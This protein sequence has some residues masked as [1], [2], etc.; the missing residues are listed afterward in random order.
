[1]FQPE[2]VIAALE[3]KA[4]HFAGYDGEVDAARERY[5]RALETLA[6]LSR[7][8]I[9]ARL[10]G[11][12]W[13]GARPTAE[14]DA[15]PGLVIPFEQVWLNHERARAWAKR[16]LT[17]VTTVAVDGSQI[18]P[19]RTISAPVG[20]VQ[21]GWFINPHSTRQPY[22][23]DIA[24]EV[25]A[26]DELAD[27]DEAVTGFPDWRVNQ[28]RFERECQR[29]ISLMQAFHERARPETPTPVFFFDG[30]LILSFAAQMR[31]ARQ[32]P[33][34]QA[35]RALLAASERYRVPVVGYVDVSYA[36][37]L[38]SMLG[39]LVGRSDKSAFS[40]GALLRSRMG[41]GDR[42][43]AWICARDDGLSQDGGPGGY[44]DQVAFVYLKTTADRPPARL[45]LPRWLLAEGEEGEDKNELE[46][47][48]DVVRAE[49]IVGNGYPYAIETADAVAV[50]TMQDRERFYRVFQAFIE[51]EG[52]PLR[53]SRKMVSKRGR[54]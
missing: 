20:A 33:Y 4:D 28:R 8:E 43:T 34:V 50:I 25:L 27:E 1:M 6:D 23:K 9:D 54:R 41:W 17:G 49:C 45:D 48:V 14:H 39:L 36:K 40:D 10:A 12:A 29:L 2:K 19:T 32:R 37:D 30:S 3:A 31:P 21:I 46:R 26:P 22:V 42:S 15:H 38:I 47:V 11:I 7:E 5:E 53:F 51:R 24:F 18:T 35:V 44:Y 16:V 52:L 13:P